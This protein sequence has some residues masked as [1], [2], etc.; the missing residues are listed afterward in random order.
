MCLK[1]LPSEKLQK[2]LHFTFLRDNAQLKVCI[3]VLNQQLVGF[4]HSGNWKLFNLFQITKLVSYDTKDYS[5][6]SK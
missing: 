6:A 4:Q 5:E 2:L 1:P 3:L